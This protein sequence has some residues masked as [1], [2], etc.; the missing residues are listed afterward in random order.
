MRYAIYMPSNTKDLAINQ[1]MVAYLNWQYATA[2]ARANN[3]ELLRSLKHLMET[4]LKE[5]IH[6]KAESSALVW[7]TEDAMPEYDAIIAMCYVYWVVL[8][9]IQWCIFKFDVWWLINYWKDNSKS[10]ILDVIMSEWCLLIHVLYIVFSLLLSM[11]LFRLIC[12]WMT[13]WWGYLQHLN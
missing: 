6:I 5:R 4:R 7:T 12:L 8:S 3:S 1:T 11:C 2:F 13:Y 9:R 10:Y